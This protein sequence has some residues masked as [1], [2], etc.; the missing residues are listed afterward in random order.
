MELGFTKL[1]NEVDVEEATRAGLISV[2][3]KPFTTPVL[4]QHLIDFGLDIEFSTHSN[5]RGLSGWAL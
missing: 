3:A 5:I 4:Q 1:V 2:D